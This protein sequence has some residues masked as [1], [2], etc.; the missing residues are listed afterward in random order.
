MTE[1]NSCEHPLKRTRQ[2]GD[3]SKT[4]PITTSENNL[5]QLAS[6]SYQQSL[7]I[8]FEYVL[9]NLNTL[10]LILLPTSVQLNMI[11]PILYYEGTEA[12][13]DLSNLLTVCRTP[14]RHALST[15]ANAP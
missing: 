14:N 10:S 4:D 5:Y 1:D 3:Q 6:K 12:H 13:G 2:K 15:T 11:S 8:S 9:G 7:S